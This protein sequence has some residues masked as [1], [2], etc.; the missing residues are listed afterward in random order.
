MISEVQF[1]DDASECE[2]VDVETNVN[3]DEQPPDENLHAHELIEGNQCFTSKTW[4]WIQ[5]QLVETSKKTAQLAY[6]A[7][8][9]PHA[10]QKLI[11]EVYSGTGL[12]GEQAER[13]RAEVMRFGGWDFSKLAHRRRLMELACELESDEIYMSPKC[14]LWSPMRAT[15]MRC[16][17]GWD[18]RWE[19][20]DF[21][22]ELHLKF[23]KKLH[24]FQ[25]KRGAHA[26]IE[27]PLRSAYF[28]LCQF[29]R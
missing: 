21:D 18:E 17:A 15:N 2:L 13:F 24:W 22:H 12:L 6:E 20:Q 16:E 26:H 19:R 29:A 8:C 10:R 5:G 25:V 11:W 1:T 14:T 28:C 3:V 9:Q 7:R 4:S 27:H 23:C